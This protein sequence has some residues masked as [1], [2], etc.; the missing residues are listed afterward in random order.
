[1]LREQSAYSQPGTARE[2]YVEHGAALAAEGREMRFSAHS[3]NDQAA[4]KR[5][6][7]IHSAVAQYDS[8]LASIDAGIAVAQDHLQRARADEAS[9]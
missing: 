4:P 2:R 7:A 6:V 8:K 9:A 3:G 5:L 1:M